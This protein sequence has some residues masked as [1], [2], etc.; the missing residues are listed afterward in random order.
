VFIGG[1]LNRGSQA[2][3]QLRRAAE[4][5]DSPIPVD[6]RSALARLTSAWATLRPA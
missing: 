2:A 5:K 3:D 4:E 6:V 1:L